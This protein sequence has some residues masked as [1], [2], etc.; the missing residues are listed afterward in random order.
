MADY[1]VILPQLQ[2]SSLLMVDYSHEE[3][4]VCFHLMADN[5]VILPKLQFSPQLTVEYSHL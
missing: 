5:E 4:S 1:G 2:F 3:R